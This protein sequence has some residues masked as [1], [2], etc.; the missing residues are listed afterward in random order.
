MNAT[1]IISI[2]MDALA[3][4]VIKLIL[5]LS[6]AFFEGCTTSNK[7]HETDQRAEIFP[8]AEVE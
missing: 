2:P 3:Y 8:Y 5:Y 6:D 7:S 4:V 1:T